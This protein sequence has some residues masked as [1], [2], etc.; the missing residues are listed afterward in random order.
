MGIRFN[1]PNLKDRR[2]DLRR[3]QTFPEKTLWSQI[4]RGSI[5]GIRFQ[6]QYSAGPFILDFYAP[7]VRL[8]IEVDG[9]T[10]LGDEAERYDARRTAYLEKWGI[11]VL[12]FSN[13]A[14]L[15]RCE[16]VIVQITAVALERMRE[17]GN[18]RGADPPSEHSRSDGH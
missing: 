10:H 5:L 15:G 11:H 16:E 9:E 13:D 12:R 7:A 18:P 2:R 4:R 3:D 8:A 17:R 14:V 1:R 6:R